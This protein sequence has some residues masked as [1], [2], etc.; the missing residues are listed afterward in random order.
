MKGVYKMD[1]ATYSQYIEDFNSACTGSKA[2]GDF[3]DKFK[4]VRVYSIY[5]EDYQV[6]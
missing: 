5:H 1:E 4:Y 6:N 3:Y 2:F